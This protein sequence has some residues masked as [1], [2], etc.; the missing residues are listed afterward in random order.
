[1]P[2]HADFIKFMK[3]S[4]VADLKNTALDGKGGSSTAAM[5]LSNFT[6]DKEYIHL[7]VAGTADINH[8]PMGVMVKTLVELSK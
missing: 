4:D 8:K 6:E 2:L 5:F 7:D 3:G 1:M